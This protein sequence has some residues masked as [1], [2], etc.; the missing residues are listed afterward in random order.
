MKFVLSGIKP[1]GIPTL[2]NYLGALKNFVKLQNEM[3]DHEFLIF[4]ADLHAI[5]AQQDPKVLKANI[6]NVSALYLACGL[7]LDNL[8]LFIQSE[9]KE[10]VELGYIMQSLAYMGELERMTQFKDKMVKQVQGVSSALFTYPALMAADIL[11]YNAKYVPVGDDQMQHLEITRTLA[12][13]FNNRYGELF[14]EP[15]GLVS[16]TSSRIMDLQDPTKKMD[17]SDG[18]NKGCIYL[19]EPLASVKKKIKAAVTDSEAVVRYDVE[20][21]PGISNLMTIYA[22]ISGLTLDQ[23]TEKYQGQGYGIFKNDLADIV[24]NELAVVQEGFKKWHDTPELHQILDE[25]QARASM[26][27]RVQIRKVKELMGLGR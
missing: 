10:H 3:K 14:V 8:T 24:A 20:N 27:A 11:L 2:G 19:L 5:T 21:K 6:M 17:K 13:R 18:E 7:D 23:I 22:A 12:N 26:F 4:V 15:V 25:G 9:V 1:T 16:K